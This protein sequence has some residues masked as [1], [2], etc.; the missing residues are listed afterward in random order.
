MAPESVQRRSDMRLSNVVFKELVRKK[1]D[2]VSGFIAILLGISVIVAVS[3]V[4]RSLKSDLTAQVHD[5]G[6]NLLILPQSARPGSYYLADFGQGEMPEEYVNILATSDLRGKVHRMVPKLSAKIEL[7]GTEVILTG[8]LPT[9]E[10]VGRPAWQIAA[11]F[12]RS[13]ERVEVH[14]H[15]QVSEEEQTWSMG[16][17]FEE[18][19][20]D[21]EGGMYERKVFDSIGEKEILLGSEVA[22]S[23]GGI[24]SVELNGTTLNISEVLPETGTVDDVRVYAHLHTVQEI[25][26][27]EKVINA[28]EVVGCGCHVDLVKLGHD[29]EK[30]LPGAKSVTIRHIAEA[31][32]NITQNL[33]KFS[34]LFSV[35]II[36]IG[37]AITANYISANVHERQSEI[38]TL[39]A[40]GATPR[41]VLAVFLQKAILLAAVGGVGGYLL[42]TALAVLV[43]PRLVDVTVLPVY[44]QIYVALIVSAVSCIVFSFVPARRAAKLDPV[45]ILR[46]E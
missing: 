23:L 44:S 27:R 40:L 18:G 12:L 1:G 39:M 37:G 6:S 21:Q 38:G 43:G 20:S 3:T 17:L 4:V 33:K 11:D 42:G 46:E 28:I 19:G 7:H 36:L 9:R 14:P 25:L 45:V 8:V 32:W 22:R 26:D 5:L 35:L 10:L 31:Q 2:F 30:L 29:V 41:M 15:E 24:N 13:E 16:S 34:L